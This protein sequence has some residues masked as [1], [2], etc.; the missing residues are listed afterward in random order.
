MSLSTEVHPVQDAPAAPKPPPTPQP[1]L[2][3]LFGRW[4]RRQSPQRQDRYATLGPL[5]SVLLF[6]AAIIS[7]FWYLRNEEIER[8][9]ESVKRDVE[10]TQNHM[11]LRL[12]QNQESLMVGVKLAGLAESRGV[13][14][15]EALVNDVGELFLAGQVLRLDAFARHVFLF[16]R[17]IL[18]LHPLGHVGNCFAVVNLVTFGSGHSFVRL[19]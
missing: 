17:A 13:V 2:Q 14:G 10:I 19:N 11:G 16:V 5:L 12:V 1:A 6:L 4:W 15:E 7:A 8:E 9:T 3:R 18:L